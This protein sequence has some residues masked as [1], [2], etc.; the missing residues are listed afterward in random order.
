MVCWR[1]RC[2][3]GGPWCGTV[4]C[5]AVLCYNGAGAGAGNA[6]KKK[7]KKKPAR[8]ILWS[9]GGLVLRF[10][11]QNCRAT[12]WSVQLETTS[13][14]DSSCCSCTAVPVSIRHGISAS[15]RRRAPARP[16]AMLPLCLWELRTLR[17]LHVGYGYSSLQPALP[18]YLRTAVVLIAMLPY[19]ILP[20]I[21][22]FQQ[23]T[24][25]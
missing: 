24:A 4:R 16:L 18:P 2:G 20:V 23:Q 9:R 21:S 13:V 14:Q 5:G 12:D 11:P 8:K 1:R 3:V 22:H 25:V 7:K 17:I 10:E 6:K 19:L 15:V